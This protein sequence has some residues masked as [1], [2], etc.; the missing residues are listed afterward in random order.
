MKYLSG[1]LLILIIGAGPLPGTGA[2]IQDRLQD[3]TAGPEMV[4]IPGACFVMGSPRTEPGHELDEGRHEVCVEDFYLAKYELSFAEYQRFAE[5]TGYDEPDDHGWGRGRLPVIEVSWFDA[6]AYVEWL[7]K[8]TGKQYRLPTEAEWEYAARAGTQ[9]A[10]WWGEQA[11]HDSANYGLDFCCGS[12][13]EGADRWDYTAPVGSF[14]ANPFGLYDTAGNVSE[15]VCS[16]YQFEYQGSETKCPN[17]GRAHAPVIRGGSWY[18][19]PAGIRSAVRDGFP[20]H[21][22]HVG[23]GF[24]PARSP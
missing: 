3:G 17:P 4:L 22:R 18:H 21:Y 9:T 15:W 20:A 16:E 12:Y 11:T 7:S 13:S 24:R 10:Y 6:V 5:A 19:G 14:A 8:Q 2:E 23:L 1:F